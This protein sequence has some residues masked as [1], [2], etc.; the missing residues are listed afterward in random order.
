M[1]FLALV[2]AHRALL[3]TEDVRIIKSMRNDVNRLVNAETGEPAEDRGGGGRADR[4]D[5]HARRRPAGSR[6]CRRRCRN[7]RSCGSRTRTCRLRELGEL[8]DPP[9]SKSAVYHRVRRIEELAAEVS[10]RERPSSSREVS[11]RPLAPRGFTVRRRLPTC[12][13]VGPRRDWLGDQGRHQRVRT[14]RAPRVPGDGGR[15]RRRGRG[16][17]R[18]D[19]REDARAPAQVRLGPRQFAARRRGGRG[20]LRS[21][22][23]VVGELSASRSGQ[24][25][26]RA[27]PCRAAVG[28]AGRRRRHRVDRLF[29]DAPR[30]RRTSTPARRRSSS[31]RRR[32]TRTSPSSWA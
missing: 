28:R 13:R 21:C 5:P 23:S 11:A 3:R 30:P 2:G 9:L 16:G 14:H 7:S 8:A 19:R 17:Q 20:R 27:R 29:T 4:G 24:G 12:A 10:A 18:P 25:A 31:P 1:T 32:R 15:A 22:K 6:A 26:R